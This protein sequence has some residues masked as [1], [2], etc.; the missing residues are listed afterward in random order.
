[1]KRADPEFANNSIVLIHKE[2]IAN[3]IQNINQGKM[4]KCLFYT[5]LARLLLS[6]LLV[7]CPTIGRSD[8]NWPVVESC[9]IN[10]TEK[11]GGSVLQDRLYC[12]EGWIT[13]EDNSG[14]LVHCS[15]YVG[16][17]GSNSDL[18]TL[19]EWQ[20]TVKEVQ[21]LQEEIT[22]LASLLV[23]QAGGDPMVAVR[24]EVKNYS[25]VVNDLKDMADRAEER[26]RHLEELL[27]LNKADPCA[28]ATCPEHPGAICTVVSSKC[29]KQRTVFINEVGEQLDCGNNDCP[30]EDECDYNPCENVTCRDYPDA[31]CLVVSCCEDYDEISWYLNGEYIKCPNEVRETSKRKKRSNHEHC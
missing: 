11:I 22:P 1:M 13:R 26:V 27:G 7:A 19:S 29:G 12:C 16:K 28:S 6:L 2:T 23:G 24:E 4:R 31:V 17:N 25:G 8:P 14:N 10:V 20:E 15:V 3:T 5:R 9:F 30:I 21:K 18:I